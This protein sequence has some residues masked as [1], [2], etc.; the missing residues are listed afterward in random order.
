MEFKKAIRSARKLRLAIAAPSGGGKTYSALR[1]AKGIVQAEGGKIA[2]IDTENNSA[3]L[4][5]HI[6]DF[7]VVNVEPLFNIKDF[8]DAIE[9]AKENGYNVLI[10]DSSSHA[11]KQV[12]DIVDKVTAGSPSKNSYTSWRTGTSI[13]DKWLQNVLFYP[14]HVIFCMRSKMEY[15]MIQNEKGKS[16]VEKI[17]LAPV[18][19]NEIEY[20]FDLMLDGNTDHYFKVTKSRY[21]KFSD[22][23]IEKPDERFGKEL[24]EWLTLNDEAAPE[25]EPEP[26]APEPEPTPA[27]LTDNKKYNITQEPINLSSLLYDPATIKP[28]FDPT[29]KEIMKYWDKCKMHDVH[30]INSLKKYLEVDTLNACENLHDLEIYLELL[31]THWEKLSGSKNGS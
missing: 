23:I 5:S 24:I 16:D 27:P 25:P 19:R 18:M 1:I 22:Q 21:D 20:E 14:G 30:R 11:W 6:F 17:G 4:Y 2:F 12:L 26:V 13:M 28:E 31:K 29:C 10:I 15:V 7:D 3:S 8:N 9:L